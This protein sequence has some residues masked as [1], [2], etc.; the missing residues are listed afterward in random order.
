MRPGLGGQGF[1]YRLVSVCACVCKKWC[2]GVVFL[3]KGRDILSKEGWG[4]VRGATGNTA[5][6]A[7]RHK[8]GGD[9]DGARR[10]AQMHC[11]AGAKREATL[12]RRRRRRRRPRA[13]FQGGDT[14]GGVAGREAEGGAGATAAER[15]AAGHPS[16]ACIGGRRWGKGK[17]KGSAL[18]GARGFRVAVPERGE[19]GASAGARGAAYGRPPGSRG[20]ATGHQEIRERGEKGKG[21]REGPPGRQGGGAIDSV[22]R[23]WKKGGAGQG[24]KRV[25]DRGE[26]GCMFPCAEGPGDA[27]AFQNW[28]GGPLRACIVRRGTPSRARGEEARGERPAPVGAACGGRGCRAGGRRAAGGGSKGAAAAPPRAGWAGGGWVVIKS[29][30]ASAAC[31]WIRAAI[32][33]RGGKTPQ[34]QVDSMGGREPPREGREG[35]ALISKCAPGRGAHVK[36]CRGLRGGQSRG[37][38]R[39]AAVPRRAGCVR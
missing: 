24:E 38:P 16:A 4:G 19:G 13:A 1:F 5:G 30:G 18:R 29:T 20:A 6:G 12:E 3:R 27:R 7:W 37:P 32:S 17:R 34:S 21:E 31:C 25:Y 35:R 15:S 8:D 11:A 2:C 14:E 28:P 23:N 10:P 39:P 36:E 22:G 9:K 33:G 26:R